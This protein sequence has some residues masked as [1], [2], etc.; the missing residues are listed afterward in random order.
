M[1]FFAKNGI[2]TDEK[3]TR[4][5]IKGIN[6]FGF[7]TNIYTLHGLWSVSMDSLFT[8]LKKNK[9]NAIRLPV[10]LEMVLGMDT[11]KS[12]SINTQENPKLVGATAGKAFDIVVSKCKE[13]GMLVLLDMHVHKASGPIEDLWWTHEY[14]EDQWIQGWKKLVTRYKSD[15][16]VFACDLKN[17]PH[18]K[19]TW[20][21]QKRDTNWA[22]ASQKIAAAI[23]AINPKV[24]IFVEGIENVAH[25]KYG[26]FW[27][28]N[29]S[30]VASRPLTLTIPNKLVYSPHV[31]GP[32]VFMQSYF[33]DTGFPAN[34][35]IIWKEQFGFIKEQRLGTIVVGEWG[36]KMEPGSLDEKWQN[37]FG[38]WLYTNN[39]DSFYWCLNCNSGDTHGLVADDWKT[40][41][42]RKLDLLARVYP[43]PTE[44][45]LQFKT[46]G[47][48]S[49]S[50]CIDTSY[51]EMLRARNDSA[52]LEYRV[53]STWDDHSKVEC[54]ITNTSNHSLHCEV[55]HIQPGHNI[56][57]VWNIVKGEGTFSFP[58]WLAVSGLQPLQNFM[59]GFICKGKVPLLKLTNDI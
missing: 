54:K 12:T 40:P 8:F 34:M 57:Q 32:S 18:G 49:S 20:D 22:L 15:P 52:L 25:P 7:E 16:H 13:Y 29:L 50:T 23:H 5:Q 21:A 9:F 38:D 47:N 35:P 14:T 17:E 33:T 53:V 24:L 48:S 27:G 1:E 30:D 51:A 37:A 59:F 31:Y 28:G 19:A 3:G 39:I 42:Q 4:V 10:S 44:F 2:I 45:K 46:S 41:V 26:S 36:G 43:S 56:I 55:I 11:L 6:W 58:D